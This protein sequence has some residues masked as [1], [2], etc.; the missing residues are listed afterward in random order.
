M[1]SNG[2]RLSLLNG[3]CTTQIC[4]SPVPP[5][6]WWPGFLETP[7]SNISLP[8][9]SDPAPLRVR[10]GYSTIKMAHET[11]LLNQTPSLSGKRD[12]EPK[13]SAIVVDAYGTD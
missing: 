3:P 8:V 1:I 6:P 11:F 12:V 10:R 9:M 2:R 13:I 4:L 5:Y 7:V